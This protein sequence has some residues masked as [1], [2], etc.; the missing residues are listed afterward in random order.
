MIKPHVCCLR[1][2]LLN[3]LLILCSKR[4]IVLQDAILDHSKSSIILV[5]K[6]LVLQSG[7]IQ[8][9]PGPPTHP[10]GLC[11][12]VVRSNQK[13]I[14]CEEC[15]HWFHVNCTAMS[16]NLVWICNFCAFP[17]FSTTFLLDNLDSLVS[18]NSYQTLEFNN[19]TTGL[20][21]DQS[22]SSPM[23]PPPHTSS[24]IACSPNQK[25]RKLK[26]ISLNCNSIK[27]CLTLTILH[28]RQWACEWN[29][30][31]AQK[32]K[33]LV[34]KKSTGEAVV[35]FQLFTKTVHKSIFMQI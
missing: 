32:D 24:L 11:N 22:F 6:F 3:G 18:M 5:L 31:L 35:S 4:L 10:C 30:S 7:D 23:E 13:A 2:M 29:K 14:E 16:T 8:V 15:L 21:R 27:L 17:N 9:N 33:S 28:T 20:A 19:S 1:Q 34:Q 26:V 25:R 12:K